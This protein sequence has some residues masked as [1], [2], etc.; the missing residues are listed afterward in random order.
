[1]CTLAS[2]QKSSMNHNI[3]PVHVFDWTSLCSWTEAIF[4]LS[5]EK[6][7][8]ENCSKLE[9]LFGSSARYK[10]RSSLAVIGKCMGNAEPNCFRS[11]AKQ[12]GY[13]PIVYVPPSVLL[14]LSTNCHEH[15]RQPHTHPSPDVTF[16]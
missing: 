11:F 14:A 2:R 16:L 12:P 4:P 8:L 7:K 9:S 6:L 15:A 10:F 13:H 5:A 3:C 1:M